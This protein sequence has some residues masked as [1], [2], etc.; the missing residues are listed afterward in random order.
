MTDD[1]ES[2]LFT[3]IVTGLLIA[4]LFVL[5]VV[6]HSEFNKAEAE[7]IYTLPD[8]TLQPLPSQYEFYSACLATVPQGVAEA[9]GYDPEME[10]DTQF[11]T[12]TA[13]IYSGCVWMM[14]AGTYEWADF[15]K[16]AQAKGIDAPFAGFTRERMIKY[17]QLYRSTSF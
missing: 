1:K 9:Y 10:L 12:D 7:E 8:T 17:I 16:W 6:V 2:T 11:M 3:G 4:L 13:M 15:F 14:Q 5:A